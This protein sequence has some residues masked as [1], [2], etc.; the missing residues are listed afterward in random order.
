M[1]TPPLTLFYSYAH[2]DEDLRDELQKHLALLKRDGVIDGWHDREIEAGTDW[3]G[4]ISKHLEAADVVLF[5]VSADFLASD[6]CWEVEVARAMARHKGGEARVIPV[7]LRPCNW[8]RAPFATIQAVPKD[9]KP[10]TRWD[11]QD[12]AFLNV[13]QAIERAAESIRTT[14]TLTPEPP[15]SAEVWNLPPPTRTFT[16]RDD[17]LRD[18]DTQLKK[19][20]PIA[21]TAL[22]G[23]GGIGKTQVA[24]EFARRHRDRYD[25]GWFVRAEEPG[26]LRADL[27]ALAVHLG[28]AEPA[29]GPE[30]TMAALREWWRTHDRWLLLFDNAPNAD[31]VRGVL[32]KEGGGHVVITSRA[33]AWRG[34]ARKID[35]RHLSRLE[36]VALLLRSDDA[37]D[38]QRAAVGRV[39]EELGDLPLALEQAA[40]YVD[41][42]GISFED[43]LNLYRQRRADLLAR[44]K[45]GDGYPNTV[46]TTWDLAFERAEA[47][48]PAAGGLLRLVACLAP[49]DL[50]ADLIR[51]WD[52]P[53]PGPLDAIRTD[54]LG[55]SDALAALRHHSLVR[56]GGNGT[57]SVHRLVQAVML[58]RM[59]EYEQ[60]TWADAARR[61]LV[62]RL[63]VDL[64]IMSGRLR[65]LAPLVPHA[66]ASGDLPAGDASLRIAALHSAATYSVANADYE[67]TET[68]TR[69]LVD[70]TEAFRDA[71]HPD[72]GTQLN[73]LGY[74]LQYRGDLNG[75]EDAFRRALAI[76]DAAHGPDHPQVAI[77]TNNLGN[78]LR[79]RGDLDGAE[80]AFRRALAIDD[81]AHGP[82]H[83]EVATDLNN[84][85]A[86]LRDRGDLDG[87]EDAYR[88]ALAI[89][90][91]AYG[92]DH[93]T[94]AI[95]VSN[96][97]SVLRDRGDLDGAED[98][99]RRALAIFEKML[100]PDHP[101]AQIARDKLAA[102]RR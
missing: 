86:V 15:I 50:P 27:S 32:P 83:P 7:I 33:Q 80:D 67:E 39:A 6:Y 79:D 85:G 70:L 42:A 49:D 101:D 52:E 58:D 98:A 71:D 95:R 22:A 28:I 66:L 35:V 73:N 57:F 64:P 3:D 76:G 26:V 31:A 34:T 62:S 53:W 18:V 90:E 38:V 77:Y 45:I 99:F 40:A 100:G 16:G 59:D 30:A 10:V 46:A 12:E 102:L 5:L 88:R 55:W 17:L 68:L 48:C 4:E 36:S 41:A 61:L 81:A 89:G 25:V 84:L 82:D 51:S 29:V 21:L 9:A 56:V 65:E 60:A 91:A 94:V 19:G 44:G 24:L 11:D 96:L 69:R 13:A 75:A 97:G 47:E 74:V 8:T 93:P 63:G 78:V 2:A 23:L 1:E 72:V 54:P 14:R 87:A 20:G 37:T 43:Y 92:S